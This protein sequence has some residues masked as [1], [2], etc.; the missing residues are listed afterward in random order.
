MIDVNTCALIL[1]TM[2]LHL[3]ISNHIPWP[4]AVAFCRKEKVNFLILTID[5]WGYEYPFSLGKRQEEVLLQSKIW[6]LLHVT[7][8][9]DIE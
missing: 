4:A 1:C 5:L 2:R 9:Q 3:D 6:T 7:G 8:R